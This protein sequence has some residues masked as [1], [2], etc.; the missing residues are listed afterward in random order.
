[1]SSCTA[2]V[3]QVPSQHTAIAAAMAV[4][5][6]YKVFLGQIFAGVERGQ[7]LSAMASVGVPYPDV[8]LFI[9]RGESH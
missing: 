7:L 6:P 1:M 8:G 4:V 2:A 9:V 5:N 3:A